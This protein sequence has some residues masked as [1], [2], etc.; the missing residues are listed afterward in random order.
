MDAKRTR[1]Q[2][3]SWLKAALERQQAWQE[4]VKMRW[5][6]KKHSNVVAAI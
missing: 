4:D 1:E 3:V 2:T 5:A 6:E